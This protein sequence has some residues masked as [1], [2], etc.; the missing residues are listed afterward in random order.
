MPDPRVTT[1]DPFT[2][3]NVTVCLFSNSVVHSHAEKSVG[4][5]FLSPEPEV[6]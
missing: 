5:F 4:G 6:T 2:L 3:L 1:F